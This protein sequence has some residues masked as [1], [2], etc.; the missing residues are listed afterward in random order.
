LTD[1]SGSDGE[2]AVPANDKTQ[3]WGL[4]G[5]VIGFLCCPPAGLIFGVLSIMEAGKVGKEK[6]L[7][8]AAIVV[9]LLGCVVWSIIYLTV[10]AA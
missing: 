5:I 2:P 8:I 3:L 7:G 4:L 10:S 9:S 1:Q 6:T